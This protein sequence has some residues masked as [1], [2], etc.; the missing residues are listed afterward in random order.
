MSK[1]EVNLSVVLYKTSEEDVQR[2]LTSLQSVELNYMLYVIDNSPTDML[3]VYFDNISSIKYI[4]NPA[5]PGFGASHNIAINYTITSGVPFHF[6]INPDTYFYNDVISDMI[7]FIKSD[8]KIGMLMP[9]VL[10]SDGS[11][12]YLPK[13]LPTP[14]SILLRRIKWPSKLYSDFISNYEL[15][16]VPQNKIYQAPILSGCFT[17]FRVKCLEDIGLYDDRFFMYFEDWDMSRRMHKVYKTIYYPNVSIFHG[18]EGASR[19][20][21]KMFKIHVQSAIHY[22]NKWGW[23]FDFERIKINKIVLKQFN[24]NLISE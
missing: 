3:K 21:F 16:Y 2:I 13:L 22:F 9:Q 8:D 17:L 18:Y 11:V 10:N 14:F 7:D 20:S 15:R 24:R 19:K 6:V 23:F 5:N 1:S 12:Q 4:H